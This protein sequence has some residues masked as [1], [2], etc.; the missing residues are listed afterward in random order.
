MVNITLTNTVA[1]SLACAWSKLEA[2]Y[3]QIAHNTSIDDFRE[4][5]KA[6]HALAKRAFG[7][8]LNEQDNNQIIVIVQS[9]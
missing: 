5:D 8:F 2:D 9:I 6:D 1:S 7:A 4:G 3:I